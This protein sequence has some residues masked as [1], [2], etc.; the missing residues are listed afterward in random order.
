MLGLEKLSLWQRYSFYLFFSLDLVTEATED[1]PWR[2][3]VREI[4]RP[5]KCTA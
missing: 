5:G 2:T 1:V 4:S 3:W